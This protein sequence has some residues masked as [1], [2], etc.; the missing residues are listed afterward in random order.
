[1]SDFCIMLMQHGGN[2]TGVI[3]RHM[4][5]SATSSAPAAY[6]YNNIIITSHGQKDSIHTFC[7]KLVICGK[8]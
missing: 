4:S 1:M 2:L 3:E 8:L 5:S 6:A 7:F